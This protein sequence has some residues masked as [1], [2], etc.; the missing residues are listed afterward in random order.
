MRYILFKLASHHIREYLKLSVR[1]STK[2]RSRSNSIF[3]D[4]TESAELLMLSPLVAETIRVSII[5][6][7]MR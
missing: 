5:Y 1:V 6:E 3:V 7:G 4:N 2:A